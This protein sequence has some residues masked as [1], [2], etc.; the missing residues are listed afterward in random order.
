[1]DKQKHQ[2]EQLWRD[3]FPIESKNF[4]QEECKNIKLFEEIYQVGGLLLTKRSM[5]PTE[6]SKDSS[7]VKRYVSEAQEKT[8][9]P[10]MSVGPGINSSH[11]AKGFG[12][13]APSR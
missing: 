12:Q 4:F 5:S 6:F 3:Y 13:I 11:Y 10:R 8:I 1:M 7:I 9:S 2:E